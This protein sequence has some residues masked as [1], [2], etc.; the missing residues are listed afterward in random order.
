VTFILQNIIESGRR[1]GV[2]LKAMATL[3]PRPNTHQEPMNATSS[4]YVICVM[5]DLI[6]TW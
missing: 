2:D 5:F 1:K 6:A 3:E 4:L